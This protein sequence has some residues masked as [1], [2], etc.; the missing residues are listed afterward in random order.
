MLSCTENKLL[1]EMFLV[2]F[3]SDLCSES[4]L[5]DRTLS[6]VLHRDVVT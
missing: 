5:E 4:A 2:V 6:Q 1:S 3:T